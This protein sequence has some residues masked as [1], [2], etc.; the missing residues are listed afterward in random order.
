MRNGVIAASIQ[1]LHIF[2]RVNGNY[3]DRTPNAQSDERRGDY[4]VIDGT[5]RILFGGWCYGATLI[6]DLVS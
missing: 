2:E 6:A 1:P 5:N 4:V 3:V